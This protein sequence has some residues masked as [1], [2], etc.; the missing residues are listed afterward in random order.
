MKDKI[1]TLHHQTVWTMVAP[2]TS[3]SS[4]QQTWM[5]WR[6]I[7]VLGRIRA[8]TLHLECWWTGEH[9]WFLVIFSLEGEENSGIVVKALGDTGE[10]GFLFT[11]VSFKSLELVNS[12]RRPGRR[13]T[14]KERFSA[15]YPI[16]ETLRQMTWS[17]SPFFRNY[18][19]LADSQICM[20]CVC[21]SYLKKEKSC[22]HTA[23][24]HLMWLK[25]VYHFVIHKQCVP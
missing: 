11:S 8:A 24:K 7:T 10:G 15:L 14:S 13:R 9:V 18:Y 21:I 5:T 20:L 2:K 16:A 19:S 25:F 22:C 3:L 12:D 4:L 17:G 23:I 6:S 1:S